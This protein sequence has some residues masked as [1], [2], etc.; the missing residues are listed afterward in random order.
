MKSYSYDQL[1]ISVVYLI[2]QNDK[3]ALSELRM[4]SYTSSVTMCSFKQYSYYNIQSLK[5][6]YNINSV[7]TASLK[8]QQQTDN[9]G[10]V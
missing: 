7:R 10:L 2:W 1:A 4:A 9:R 3:I 6:S 8:Q 5:F